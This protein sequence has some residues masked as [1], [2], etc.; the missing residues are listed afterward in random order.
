MAKLRFRPRATFNADLKRLGR[1][2]PT[3]IDDVQAAIDELLENGTLSDE[4]D[5]HPLK[6]RL[7]GYR[8]FHVRDT[9][10]GKQPNDIND[11]LV[12]W[13]VEH[14]EL[15]VVGVR[16]GSHDRLFPNQNSSKKYHK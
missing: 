12:I 2:D 8:E 15:I 3:I 14:N 9:P 16:V 5:D 4:Y 13:Y 7:S 10:R 6:R 11:V 1:L